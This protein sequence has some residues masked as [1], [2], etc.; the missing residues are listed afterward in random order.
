MKFLLS[1]Y[2]IVI[3]T[4]QFSFAQSTYTRWDEKEIVLEN[5][6]LKRVILLKDAI[7]TEQLFMKGSPVNFVALL[8]INI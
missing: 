6:A 2:G 4:I 1:F 7:Y 8:T 3:L 5:S